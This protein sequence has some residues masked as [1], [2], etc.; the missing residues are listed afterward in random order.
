MTGCAFPDA[1]FTYN[2]ET[3]KSTL[4]IPPIDPESVIWSGL[5]LSE[6]EALSL[7]DVDVVQT[8]NE[9]AAALARPHNNTTVYA[10]ADQVSDHITFLQ[11]QASDLTLLKEAI[12]ECRVVKDE[13]EIALTRKAN[14][15][16]TIAHTA[17]L[18]AVKKA[19]NERELEGLF[20][21]RCIANGAREQAYHGIFA[22]G[23]AA[24]TLHYV[25]NSE[26]LEGK[27]NL[28]LDAGGEFNCYASD[29][30]SRAMSSRRD[31]MMGSTPRI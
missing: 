5:P 11:F 24:A 12:D 6:E 23:E 28:L 26:S 9:V 8:S 30:V 25:K 29:I 4:F 22:S 16:S 19:K 17:V 2:I 18:K 10:I 3:E 20:I 21:E 15:I 31:L 1:Y 7:Y 27:P 14:A 13:Y